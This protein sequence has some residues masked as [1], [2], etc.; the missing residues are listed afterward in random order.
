[1]FNLVENQP[2]ASHTQRP[3]PRNVMICSCST[4]QPLDIL[5]AWTQLFWKTGRIEKLQS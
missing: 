1:M 3:V 4:R 2:V 5:S